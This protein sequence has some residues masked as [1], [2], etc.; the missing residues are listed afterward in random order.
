[1]FA[2]RIDADTKLRLLQEP[3]AEELFALVDANRRRL[4]KWLP[5]L[6]FNTTPAD[7]LAFIRSVLN[8]LA[9]NQGFSL[10]I[11]HKGR[12]AGM[13]GMHTLSW[14]NRSV[15]LGYWL[16]E[17]FQG[18][19]L[20][21]KSCQVLIDY[22]FDEMGLNKVEIDPAPGNARS[23]AIPERL[24][25]QQEGTV[26]Q[27]EWLYDHFVDHVIYGMLAEEWHPAKNHPG[28]RAG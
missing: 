13:V 1:M 20:I 11:F 10:G 17:E 12:L 19:G 2:H 5:W 14:A 9:S 18:H 16:G 15:R 27:V 24:G 23:R 4:R 21:T 8:Q 28:R 7:S 22:A 26:R 6:D 25:F 3:H